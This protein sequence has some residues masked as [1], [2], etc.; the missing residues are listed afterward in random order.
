MRFALLLLTLTA[1]GR[2]ADC[3]DAPAGGAQRLARF[4]ALSKAAQ[5]AFQ[6][7]QYE[8]AAGNFRQALCFAPDSAFAYH[9]LGLAAAAAGDFTE[10]RR[11]LE[12]ADRLSPREFSI[13]L[14]RSQ[15]ELS[16][17]A[18]ERAG[19]L[20]AEA[21]RAAQANTE[22]GR[23]A[24]SDLHGQLGRAFLQQ[25]NLDLAL[26]QIL[27]ARRAGSGDTQTLLMLATLENNLGAYSDAIRD[28]VSVG[29]LAGA[30]VPQ[31][32]AGA[33]IAGLAY[34]NQKK[35]GDAIRLLE[36]AIGL[37]PSEIA[38]L[39]LAE[40]HETGDKPAEAVKVLERG[41]AALPSSLKIAVALGKNLTNAGDNE[42]AA[43]IL[44]AIVQNSPEELDAWRWLA[45]TES[46]LGQF[47]KAA[48]ALQQVAR[49]QP[50]YPMIDLMLAQALLKQEP[51]DEEG[52]LRAL[53]R[54]AKTSP[55]DPDVYYLRGKTYFSLNRFPEAVAALERAIELAPALAEPY[56]KLGQALQQLGRPE[57]ARRQFEKMK[58]LKSLP[59]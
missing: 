46:S 27:R 36:R 5:A 8:A 7:G 52:A 9:G 19:R 17:G 42:R 28:G 31:R 45:Q 41:M 1:V 22:A 3:P 2:A 39:A 35:N 26:A 4:E 59:R 12:Q 54:A 51:P 33:A 15:V 58:Y 34:K 11:A 30:S 13:L 16:A 10:A 6:S 20:L 29:S 57:E 24:A 43:K 21:E 37:A 50:T 25:R 32:A 47:Q 18:F 38:Y 23:R 53:D 56:Y 55:D 44:A 40:I 49:R 48:E 14:A